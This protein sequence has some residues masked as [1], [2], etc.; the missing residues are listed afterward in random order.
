MDEHFIVNIDSLCAV[1]RQDIGVTMTLHLTDLVLFLAGLAT[2]CKH[3]S[4]Q[5][6]QYDAHSVQECNM[7]QGQFDGLV[8]T[9]NT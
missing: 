6:K 8:V 2:V 5:A 9:T 4:S 1:A 7:M 3:Y